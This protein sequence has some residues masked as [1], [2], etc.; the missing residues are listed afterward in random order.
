L[1][2]PD[3]GQKNDPNDLQSSLAIKPP[4]TSQNTPPIL[5]FQRK[6]EIDIPWKDIIGSASTE[7]STS[8]A[9]IRE[10]FE[11]SWDLK[12]V[13][14]E[15]FLKDSSPYIQPTPLDTGTK[16]KEGKSVLKLMYRTNLDDPQ[17]P[18]PEDIPA[19]IVL[20]HGTSGRFYLIL[21][22]LGVDLTIEDF[23]TVESY[24][25]AWEQKIDGVEL[26]FESAEAA[27]NY[28]TDYSE[29]DLRPAIIHR[30]YNE[31]LLQKTFAENVSSDVAGATKEMIKQIID[32]SMDI[33]ELERLQEK[34]LRLAMQQYEAQ[35]R[36]ERLVTQAS[37]LGYYLFLIADNI[38]FPDTTKVSVQPGEM[39]TKYQRIA[40][41]TTQHTKHVY[42]PKKFAGIK[43][44]TRRQTVGYQRQH[45]QIVT[46]YKK[47]DTSK[48]PL[49]EEV[50]SLRQAGNEVY[51]F[52]A[53]KQ[54]F[55]TADG[56]S[57]A[58]VMDR[59]E[60]NK[61]FRQKCVVMLPVYE[62]AITGQLALTKYSVF[63]RPLRGISPTMLPRLSLVESLSYRTAW[64]ESDNLLLRTVLMDEED[65]QIVGF[66]V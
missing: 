28:Y 44:G 24:E 18:A 32:S 6:R 36:L 22:S 54:G 56:I 45:S 49:A 1:R 10:Y 40:K 65:G 21:A 57:L 64:C 37:D 59:C 42:R 9:A 35:R 62:E 47:V 66:A 30:K 7:G 52:K 58:S 53:G 46:S 13:D 48:D 14:L 26:V 34:S 12:V 33:D 63:K 25:K 19:G 11:I 50:V 4:E 41:W 39:Y 51:V 20:Q 3:L 2:L 17:K 5:A 27:T 55:A 15:D 16:D 29:I 23:K 8:T 61:A 60:F 31:L 38:T 43:V